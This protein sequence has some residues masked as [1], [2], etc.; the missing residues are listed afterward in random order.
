MRS[1]ATRID[2]HRRIETWR[3]HS[4]PRV[5]FTPPTTMMPSRTMTMPSRTTRAVA[6]SSSSRGRSRARCRRAHPCSHPRGGGRARGTDARARADEV[7]SDPWEALGVAEGASREAVKRAY[8]RLAKMHH[9]DVVRGEE[10][11][12]ESLEIF[13]RAKTA[14][15]AL[16]RAT[17][18][19]LKDVKTEAW[20]MKW[21]TQLTKMRELEL[22]RRRRVRRAREAREARA[23]SAADGDANDGD[24]ESAVGTEEMREQIDAQIAGLRDRGRRRRNVMKPKVRNW[25]EP[26]PVVDDAYDWNHSVQ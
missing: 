1:S 19:D 17:T 3:H 20:R 23:G 14:Y 10:D 11:Q 26:F 5:V 22:G 13:I 2:A 7:S 18:G 12:A 8:K 21:K 4:T 16:T 25:E 15:E 6:S 9:P 24:V